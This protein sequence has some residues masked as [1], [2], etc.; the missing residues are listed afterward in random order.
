MVKINIAN[1][2]DNVMEDTFSVNETYAQAFVD[3][4]RDT[5]SDEFPRFDPVHSFESFMCNDDYIDTVECRQ[6]SVQELCLLPTGPGSTSIERRVFLE[7]VKN[8]QKPYKPKK[9]K[10]PGAYV[11]DA[12]PRTAL[13]MDYVIR[14]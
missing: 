1:A 12:E 11:P 8:L 4:D 2:F 10:E 14:N 6:A 5:Q 13:A 3:G 7:D 9:G